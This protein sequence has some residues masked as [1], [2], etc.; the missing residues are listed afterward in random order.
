M[1]FINMPIEW[2]HATSYLLAIAMSVL[3]VT[4]CDI[5]VDK[6]LSV[7]AHRLTVL[8]IAAYNYVTLMFLIRSCVLYI[9]FNFQAILY[10]ISWSTISGGWCGATPLRCP[11]GLTYYIVIFDILL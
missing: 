3:H 8:Y 10:S 7:Y 9:F 2:L 11:L 1:S 6:M 4:V 5:I